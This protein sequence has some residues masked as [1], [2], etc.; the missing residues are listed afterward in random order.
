MT[1]LREAQIAVCLL[2][3]PVRV[4]MRWLLGLLKEWYGGFS[5]DVYRWLR[6]EE[7]GFSIFAM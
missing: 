2:M 5:F 1:N 3:F 7:V 4:P 6:M